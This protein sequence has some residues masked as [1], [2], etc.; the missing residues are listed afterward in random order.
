M[1]VQPR[2]YWVP[3]CS[4]S[5]KRHSDKSEQANGPALHV[6]VV[7]RGKKPTRNKS[8][9]CIR[10]SVRVVRVVRVKNRLWAEEL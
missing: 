1:L 4:D 9:P 6:Q 5:E 10:M 8:R 3:A 2:F 7:R